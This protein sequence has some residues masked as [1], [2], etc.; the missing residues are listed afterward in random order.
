MHAAFSSF[1]PQTDLYQNQM[2]WLVE[3]AAFMYSELIANSQI[4]LQSIHDMTDHAANAKF[5][6]WEKA[7]PIAINMYQRLKHYFHPHQ[8]GNIPSHLIAL[9]AGVIL[10]ELVQVLS[11]GSRGH[12][13]AIQALLAKLDKTEINPYAVLSLKDFPTSIDQVITMARKMENEQH[14][15]RIYKA[16]DH[17]YEDILSLTYTHD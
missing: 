15:A 9:A 17:Y 12:V 14:I 13:I 10:D 6:G 1:N 16:V 2:W 8:Q 4:V 3:N 11:Y 7:I 5:L